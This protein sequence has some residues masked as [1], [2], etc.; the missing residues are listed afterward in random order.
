MQVP[1]K[2]SKTEGLFVKVPKDASSFSLDMFGITYLKL[3]TSDN[4]TNNGKGYYSEE[5]ISISDIDKYRLLGLTN[6]LTEDICKTLVDDIDKYNNFKSYQGSINNERIWILS[7]KESL[8]SLMKTLKIYNTNP[9]I[10]P[11]LENGDVDSLYYDE[12]YVK[13]YLQ[14]DEKCGNW[15]ILIK[16]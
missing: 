11:Y 7:A 8:F 12:V 2:T 6:D 15:L 4:S 9:M 13:I 1:F 3:Y 16:K 5:N 10:Y 14:L